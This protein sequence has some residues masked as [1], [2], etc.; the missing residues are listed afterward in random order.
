MATPSRKTSGNQNAWPLLGW[1]DQTSA[2]DRKDAVSVATAIRHSRRR[3]RR[4]HGRQPAGVALA[5]Q[6]NLDYLRARFR[7]G[8]TSLGAHG[9]KRLAHSP[10]VAAVR[11]F[12]RPREGGSRS[13]TPWDLHACNRGS[14]ARALRVP[15]RTLISSDWTMIGAIATLLK[16][17]GEAGELGA[18]RYLPVPLDLLSEKRATELAPDRFKDFWRP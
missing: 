12:L 17:D 3:T 2:S 14:R 11:H 10:C 18:A 5:S 15:G 8:G 6:G 16:R 13:D 1:D 7:A 9:F 4:S